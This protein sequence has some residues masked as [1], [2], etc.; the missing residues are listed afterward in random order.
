MVSELHESA[1]EK[2]SLG[3]LVATKL[4]YKICLPVTDAL[5]K[6]GCPTRSLKH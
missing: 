5:K 2:D 6:P 3:T 1:K 4:S